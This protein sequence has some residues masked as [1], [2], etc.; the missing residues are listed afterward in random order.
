MTLPGELPRA[1]VQR[2]VRLA[3]VRAAGLTSTELS[4]PL[5]ATPWRGVRVWS[6]TEVTPRVRALGAATLLP[7]RGRVGAV[8]GWAAAHLLGAAEV[9]GLAPDGVTRRPVPLYPV[10]RH[11]ARPG[12]ELYRSR[13]DPDDVV[14]ADGVQVTSAVRTAYDL[15]RFAESLREAVVAVDQ[16]CR[17]LGVRPDDLAE[18]ANARPGWRGTT[19]LR[20]ALAHTD[21]L[22][23]SPQETRLRLVWVLD[24]R[25]PRPLVNHELWSAAGHLLGLPDLLD[26][27]SG[28]VGE[29]DGAQHRQLR[30]HTAD[31][32]REEAFE[33][34]GLTVV[35]AT[36]LDLGR[37]SLVLRL[38]AG[39][40]DA[41]TS[42]RAGWTV[43]APRARWL[44]PA[45]PA[46]L[47]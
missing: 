27:A 9:D 43:R 40:E 13:L 3:D 31:N 37:R 36:S 7:D 11:R 5:W 32:A 24:A 17:Y 2:P 46:R 15:G 18:Y 28:L 26:P 39:Y 35:R 1:L 12:I 4:G 38:G 42:P 21:P 8:A 20:Q 44:L 23:R 41:R 29:Y 30:Q 45:R 33:R 19:Q 22:A 6:A 16:A 25:L 14:L 10:R 47:G 34:E